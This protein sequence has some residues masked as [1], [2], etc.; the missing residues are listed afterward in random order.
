MQKRT[1]KQDRKRSALKL[2]F[3]SGSLHSISRDSYR[4]GQAR[5]N[6]FEGVG[7]RSKALRTANKVVKTVRRTRLA[8]QILGIGATLQAARGS[9]GF[10]DFGGSLIKNFGAKLGGRAVG[11]VGIRGTRVGSAKLANAARK[12]RAKRAQ[13][14]DV[15]FRRIRG[16]VV[17]IRQK[18]VNR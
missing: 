1:K 14:G 13:K 15:V 11:H 12:R 5:V 7:N 17:P 9:E 4:S 3:L 8:A 2:A 16:R 6:M 18:G 10:L